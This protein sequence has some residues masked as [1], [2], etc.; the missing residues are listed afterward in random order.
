MRELREMP[1][2]NNTT[3]VLFKA[4]VNEETKTG[5]FKI[6]FKDGSVT[7]MAYRVEPKAV[8][9]K[10]IQPI[11]HYTL[12]QTYLLLQEFTPDVGKGSDYHY[13]LQALIN[14][15][16]NNRFELAAYSYPN[17][18]VHTDVSMKHPPHASPLYSEKKLS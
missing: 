11:E 14:A 13:R 10:R 12:E 7:E 15:A 4:A 3:W 2:P 1:E 18:W 16:I 8:Y 9:E 5:E 6:E 17:G